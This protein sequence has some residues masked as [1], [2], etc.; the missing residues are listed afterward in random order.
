[1]I[2]ADDVLDRFWSK[3][4]TDH[5]LW[6]NGTK[7][8]IWTAS[9]ANRQG[10]GR[11]WDGAGFWVAHRFAYALE[12]GQVPDGLEVDHLCRRYKCVNHLHL[13]A[14]TPCENRRRAERH[15]IY[16]LTCPAGHL[17]TRENLQKNTNGRGDITRRCAQCNRDNVAR[18][19]EN[20]GVIGKRT[21]NDLSP[22]CKNNHPRTAANTRFDK[23]G[24]AVCRDCQRDA[25][26]R[27][28]QKKAAV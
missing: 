12:H 4:T 27:Y 18:F 20:G 24:V 13:E 19:Y 8:I 11:F 1:M 17:W 26:R 5:D 16:H 6:F 28:A 2:Y 3:T 21:L 10:Y 7:C 14:V 22:A 25:C 9:A 15:R 23:H